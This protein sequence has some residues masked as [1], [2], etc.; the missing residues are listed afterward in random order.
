MQSPLATSGN[1]VRSKVDFSRREALFHTLMTIMYGNQIPLLMQLS[2]AL[3]YCGHL[4]NGLWLCD[5]N[6]YPPRFQSTKLRV[7]SDTL[8]HLYWYKDFKMNTN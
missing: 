8:V 4:I 5:C 6:G 7:R 1:N 3:P 2:H